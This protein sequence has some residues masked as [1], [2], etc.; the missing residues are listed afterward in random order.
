[1]RR[2]NVFWGILIIV[3]GFLFLLNSMNILRIDVWVLIWPLVLISAGLWFLLA[4]VIFKGK[5]LETQSLNLPLEGTNKAFVQI[6][7]G[8]GTLN[9]KDSSETNTLLNGTFVGGLDHHIERS[10]DITSVKLK[11][12]TD[13]WWTRMPAMGFEG[14]RWDMEISPAIPLELD[15]D[16]G[17]NESFLD[18]SKLVVKKLSIDTGASSTRVLMP[19]QAGET[20]TEIKSGAASV[21]LHIPENVACKIEVESGI[22]EIKIDQNRFPKVNKI[23]QSSNF[24]SADNRAFIKIGTGV[25]SIV[26]N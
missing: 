25:G 1:M 9:I 14:H 19:E 4:P 15:I 6:Q 16:S 24:D 12:P 5:E 18:L 7:H 23:Y 3:I 13:A 20:F 22:A 8:A 17:A 26:I 2:S 11:I 10:S 21:R